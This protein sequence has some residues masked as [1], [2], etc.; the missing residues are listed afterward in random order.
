MP[1][2]TLPG[3]TYKLQLPPLGYWLEILAA[4][5]TMNTNPHISAV[6]VIIQEFARLLVDAYYGSG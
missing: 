6:E 4:R 1:L 2:R 5:Q 3:F